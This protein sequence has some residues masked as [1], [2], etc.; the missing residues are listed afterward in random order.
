MAD[1]LTPDNDMPAA[2]DQQAFK[3]G[4]GPDALEVWPPKPDNLGSE[5]WLKGSTGGP[6]A[7][8]PLSTISISRGS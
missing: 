2:E 3:R 6:Q 1:L 8:D 7:I 5:G 4:L